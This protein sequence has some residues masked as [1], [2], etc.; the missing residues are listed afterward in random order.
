MLSQAG[1]V[2]V[3]SII[4]EL[5]SLAR[6][7]GNWGSSA[8]SRLWRVENKGQ[9]RGGGVGVGGSAVQSADQPSARLHFHSVYFRAEGRQSNPR[10][11]EI[12]YSASFLR[13]SP[14]HTLFSQ[15]C[16]TKIL[17][18]YSSKQLENNS[19]L[20]VRLPALGSD[21]LLIWDFLAYSKC[22]PRQGLEHI[23]VHWAKILKL[24]YAQRLGDANKLRFVQ[25]HFP[26]PQKIMMPLQ[27][28]FVAHIG[29]SLLSSLFCVIS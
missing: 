13:A 28:L 29:F 4:L 26:F 2:W 24:V 14:I 6:S 21:W 10:L 9:L 22:S 20:L 7:T 19:N 1:A 18:L 3:G 12:L 15:H 27:G 5:L 16:Q 8:Y 25:K 23:L 11:G 17:N